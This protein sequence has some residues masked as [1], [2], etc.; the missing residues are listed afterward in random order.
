[1]LLDRI[2]KI[3]FLL[4]HRI[5]I[6]QENNKLNGAC[7]STITKSMGQNKPQKHKIIINSHAVLACI[8][9]DL[10]LNQDSCS[11]RT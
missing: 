4:F 2:S 9:E 10:E 3:Y 6:G 11:E 7:I 1:M 5:S 8:C